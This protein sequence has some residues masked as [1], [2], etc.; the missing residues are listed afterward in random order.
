MNAILIVYSGKLK[1][2]LKKCVEF[3]F[4]CLWE[5]GLKLGIL[6]GKKLQKT[7]KGYSF[8]HIYDDMWYKL[9]VNDRLGSQV[10]LTSNIGMF[11]CHVGGF[12]GSDHISI[13]LYDRLELY[14]TYKWSDFTDC[15]LY[16]YGSW[17]HIYCKNKSVVQVCDI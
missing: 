16:K 2:I 17:V 7:I 10:H 5:S 14:N 8:I 12:L 1:K 9:T 4:Q 13:K 3:I 15:K 11:H 6:W